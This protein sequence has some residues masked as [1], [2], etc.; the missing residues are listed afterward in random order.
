[1]NKALITCQMIEMP[2]K[3]IQKNRKEAE[4]K[5]LLIFTSSILIGIVLLGLLPTHGEDRIYDSVI[6]LHVIANS[7]SDYDQALKLKVR[8]RVLER[9]SEIVAG[10]QSR[11][12]A[13]AALRVSLDKVEAAA[14][15]AIS[16][17]G[18]DCRVKVELGEEEYPTKSYE[19]ICFPAGRYMSL[20]VSIGESEGE[21]WWCVLFPNLCLSAATKKRV[22]EAFVE[23]GLTPEQYRI[24][25]ET[26]DAKYSVRF[27]V[28]ELIEQ[29]FRK[30]KHKK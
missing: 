10:C 5:K 30:C 3:A 11:A 14:A 8:D 12:E 26:R 29:I 28:L 23:V 9:A 18:S 19:S 1:V 20:R 16:A 24:I 7:N 2:A 22:E 13:E 25:T 27:K 6:R 17:A 21:N 15:E 4:M